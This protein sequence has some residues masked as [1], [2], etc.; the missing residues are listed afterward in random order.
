MEYNLTDK[1]HK[2]WRDGKWQRSVFLDTAPFTLK[3][4]A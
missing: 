4:R 1:E 2:K 3:E